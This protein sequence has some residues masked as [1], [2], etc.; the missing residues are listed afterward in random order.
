MATIPMQAAVAFSSSISPIREASPSNRNQVD[1]TSP[2]L[3]DLP[4]EVRERIG[5][6][7]FWT[8]PHYLDPIDT[9]WRDIRSPA[10]Q[11]FYDDHFNL[12]HQALGFP[13]SYNCADTLFRQAKSS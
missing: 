2:E 13:R 10:K 1:A 4:F 3:R 9:H 11:K 7:V 8:E 5:H 12:I 6:L